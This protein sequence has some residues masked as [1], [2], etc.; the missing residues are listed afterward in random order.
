MHRLTLRR[1][2]S[3]TCACL[4]LLL[5]AASGEHWRIWVH[6]PGVVHTHRTPLGGCQL[7]DHDQNGRRDLTDT[8]ILAKWLAG[9]PDSSCACPPDQYGDM[10]ADGS[11]NASDLVEL[12]R[13]ASG[14]K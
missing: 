6:G 8:A 2:G 7:G 12:L 5:A 1:N 11:V 13:Q 10:T 3:L 4:A 9:S 14:A